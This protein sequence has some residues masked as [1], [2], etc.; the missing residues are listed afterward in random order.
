MTRR[1][2]DLLAPY[3]FAREVGLTVETPHGL[4]CRVPIVPLFETIDDLER[5]P[6]ILRTFLQHPMTVRSVKEQCRERGEDHLVQEVMVGY[7][8]SNKDGGM[9]ASLWS[10]YRAEASLVDVG[11][12]AGVRIRFLHGRGGTLSRGGGPEHRFVKA[13]HP[14]ALGG[15]LRLTEQGETIAQKYA[16]RLT[17]VYN[18]ELLFAGM[19]RATL[20]ERYSPEPGHVLEPTMD[21]LAIESRRVYRRLLETDGFLT[22]FRQATPIDVIEESRIGSRP[23]RRTGQPGLAD[24]RAIPWVFS[25]NQARFYVSGWYGVGSALERL[26]VERP[27]QFAR[28]SPHLY[29]WA[30]LHYALSN[31]ATCLAAADPHVMFEYARLVEDAELRERFLAQIAEELERTSRMLE[32]IYGGPLAARRPNIEASLCVRRQPLR[33]LHRRQIALLREWRGSHRR[34]DAE[35]AAAL[36]PALLLT[37]N[38]IASGLGATG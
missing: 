35:G 31:T 17:A 19:T 3:L 10:L 23:S 20:L 2:S 16:N 1:P 25:W 22:F 4:A 21:W 12:E 33:V 11:R 6:D 7:S 32:R 29:T 34:G 18:L 8:D 9:L 14:S 27:A 15:D 13:I 5:S 24:L 37:V 36:L 30:P 28:L 38:A 26:S